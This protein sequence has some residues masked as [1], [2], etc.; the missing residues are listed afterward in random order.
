MEP[1]IHH[2]MQMTIWMRENIIISAGVLFLLA[3]SVDSEHSTS[4][5]LLAV[6]MVA[7]GGKGREGICPYWCNQS[8]MGR[9]DN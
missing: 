4:S 5:I 7:R 3:G 8:Q 2:H 1:G 9:M 6:V